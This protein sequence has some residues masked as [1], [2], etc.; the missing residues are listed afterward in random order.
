ML[1]PGENV[2]TSPPAAADVPGPVPPLPNVAVPSDLNLSDT[3]LEIVN[4]VFGYTS[5][6]WQSDQL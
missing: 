4:A 5:L 1:F 2:G 3:A 6:G